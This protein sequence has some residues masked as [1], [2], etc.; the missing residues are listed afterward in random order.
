MSES[1][2]YEAFVPTHEQEKTIRKVAYIA[3][4]TVVI[5]LVVVLGATLVMYI[6]DTSK[7]PGAGY[8]GNVA[9]WAAALILLVMVALRLRTDYL[10]YQP[11]DEDVVDEEPVAE[12][13]SSLRLVESPDG[14]RWSPSS[15]IWPPGMLS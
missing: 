14:D 11:P 6:N 2:N 12:S 1:S 5:T 4:L 13:Q 8:I 15:E 3:S 7:D 9:F 10:G